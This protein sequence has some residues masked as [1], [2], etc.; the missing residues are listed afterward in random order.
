MLI[1]TTLFMQCSESFNKTIPQPEDNEEEL[2]VIFGTPKVL[3]ILVDG[4]RGRSVETANIPQMKSLLNNSIY[5]WVSLGDENAEDVMSNWTDIF[6][7]V[8]NNKHGILTDDLGTNRFQNYPILFDRISDIDPSI[9]SE[10]LTSSS[11]LE[12]LLKNSTSVTKLQSD[13]EVK[14]RIVSEIKTTDKKFVTVHFTDIDKIGQTEGYDNTI[15]QYKAAIEKFD[16]YV[17]E[18]ISSL[19]SRQEYGKENWLVII[20][21]SQGGN[22]DIPNNENDNTIFSNPK[23]NGFTIMYSPKYTSYYV[24]KPY[25]GNRFI[26]DFIRFRDKEHLYQVDGDQSLYNIGNENMT[27]ELKLKK[28]KGPNNNYQFNYAALIGKRTNWQSGWGGTDGSVKGWVI[29]LESNY[30]VF[31]AAGTGAHNQF[32]SNSVP[33]NDGTWN[34]ITAVLEYTNGKRTINLYTNGKLASTGDMSS[35]GNIDSKPGDIFRIGVLEGNSNWNNDC[36]IAD[37][38]IWKSALSPEVVGQYACEVGV[39]ETHPYYNYL[40]GYWPMLSVDNGIVRDEGPFGSHMRMSNSNMQ[41]N[42]QNDY[43][44][45]PSLNEISN[46]VIK[47]SDI[48]AQILAWLKISRQESWQLDGRV[49]VK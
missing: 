24:S 40:A 23:L 43:I 16:G 19:K 46:Q 6:T 20:Q 15:P 45:S 1:F 27:I 13:I 33:L 5:S 28:N 4:A 18:I 7:G 25:M 29:Y 38:R 35:Y 48:P 8:R 11:K 2:D 37:V 49:W 34:T 39:D 47:N 3:L 41:I 31:N 12:S 26:G 10:V 42:R 22:F 30:W 14:N 9:S 32:K 17:G 44:C 21:S 36:Q